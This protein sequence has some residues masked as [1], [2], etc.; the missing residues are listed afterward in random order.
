MK[1]ERKIEMSG[2][3]GTFVTRLELPQDVSVKLVE[4]RVEGDTVEVQLSWTD[5]VTGH[6]EETWSSLAVALVRVAA[7]AHC[8]RDEERP[9]AFA[10]ATSEQFGWESEAAL[11][12]LTDEL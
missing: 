1:T 5:N 2:R 11:D 12:H 10:F 9:R 4:R 3:T 7:L 6:W 8:V